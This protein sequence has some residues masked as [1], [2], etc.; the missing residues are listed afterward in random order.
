MKDQL[1]VL[2]SIRSSV[3]RWI[4]AGALALAIIVPATA[5]PS[6]EDSGVRRQLIPILGFT[7]DNRA[8]GQGSSSCIN[9]SARKSSFVKYR[10]HCAHDDRKRSAQLQS[11]RTMDFHASMAQPPC[12]N[13]PIT[14]LRGKVEPTFWSTFPPSCSSCNASFSASP[15][16]SI[17][18]PAA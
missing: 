5:L 13:D 1:A 9:P 10:S 18:P 14:S 17:G 2:P 3:G 6:F 8:G 4:M 7:T 15:S 16:D 12:E 11:Q